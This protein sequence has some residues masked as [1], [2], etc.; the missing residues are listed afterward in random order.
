MNSDGRTETFDL[1]SNQIE[2]EAHARSSRVARLQRLA[3]SL[4]GTC[5]RYIPIGWGLRVEII[6]P[7]APTA[8]PKP[9]KGGETPASEGNNAPR[10][11]PFSSFPIS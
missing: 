11:Q 2:R 7:A 4:D 6:P 8:K 1:V 5:A 9:S 10:E 3:L